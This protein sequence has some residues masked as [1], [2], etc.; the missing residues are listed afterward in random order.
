MIGSPIRQPPRVV[1]LQVRPANWGDEWGRLPTALTHSCRPAEHVNPDGFA[2]SVGMAPGPFRRQSSRWR[3]KRQAPNITK[4]SGPKRLGGNRIGRIDRFFLGLGTRVRYRVGPD[5]PEDNGRSWMAVS[6]RD[7]RHEI[8]A[9]ADHLGFVADKALAREREQMQ[10]F[11]R[12]LPSAAWSRMAALPRTKVMSPIW[13]SPVYGIAEGTV[14]FPA[15]V[16]AVLLASL[17]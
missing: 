8:V 3:L 16:I 12:S 9:G 6:V 14:R 11:C 15:V 13:P 7:A 17:S 5:Q 4:P 2:A 10:V 1:W